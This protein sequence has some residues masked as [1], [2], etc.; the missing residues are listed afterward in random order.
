MSECVYT[1][2]SVGK[3][4]SLSFLLQLPHTDINDIHKGI[5]TPLSAAASNNH[6]RCVELLLKDPRIAINMGLRNNTPLFKAA[7]NNSVGCLQLLLEDGNVLVNLGPGTSPLLTA[8]SN[9]FVKCARLLL[10]HPRIDVNHQR[11]RDSATALY[12]AAYYGYDECLDLVLKHPSTDPNLEEGELGRTPLYIS[13]LKGNHKSIELLVLDDRTDVNKGQK[14]NEDTPLIA[15]AWHGNMSTLKVLFGDLRIN[16]N[17]PNIHGLTPLM[18]ATRT[19]V[20]ELFLNNDLPSLVQSCPA[21][22]ERTV[23]TLL[24]NSVL[25]YEQKLPLFLWKFI[26]SFVQPRID[27]NA[28]IPIQGQHPWPIPGASAL[29]LAV[30]AN[31]PETVKILLECPDIDVNIKDAVNRTALDL[32][33]ERGYHEIVALLGLA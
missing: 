21:W 22:L 30:A 11:Q 19:E 26:F 16:P 25:P 4:D 14:N 12:T 17:K 5:E 3:I 15:A 9:G 2:A 29:I 1:A 28:T 6:P 20:V 10:M 31:K 27:V 18:A 23:A 8:V 7:Q 13:V 32:A 33:I 24:C